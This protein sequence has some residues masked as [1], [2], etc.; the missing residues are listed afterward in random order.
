MIQLKEGF[1][2]RLQELHTYLD[3]LDG[4]EKQVQGGLPR[5]GQGPS[6]LTISAQQQKILY[7]S[8]YLQLY[9][10]VE[11]TITRCVDALSDAVIEQERWFPADLTAELRREWVRYIARPQVEQGADRRLESTMKLCEHLVQGHPLSQLKIV[12]GSDGNWDDNAIS[13]L[14]ERLGLSLRIQDATVAPI[15]RHFRDDKGALS[16]IKITRNKLAHGSLSFVECG[17]GVTAAELRELTDKTS[18]YLREVVESFQRWIDAH[19][20]I[21][22]D[23]R[24]AVKRA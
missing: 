3:L 23:R 2:E 7:S 20:F 24:P 14:A 13:D 8:V 5:L 19:E 12:K 22:P 15:K 9:N 11:A 17:D 21:L 16:F 1:D 6:G 10:L 4:I 18:T